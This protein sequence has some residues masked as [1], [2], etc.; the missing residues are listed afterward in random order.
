MLMNLRVSY[1]AANFLTPT[2][3][4]RVRCL[5]VSKKK[6]KSDDLKIPILKKLRAKLT[7]VQKSSGNCS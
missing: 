3:L 7:N 6:K 1:N 4:R 2:V 5:V